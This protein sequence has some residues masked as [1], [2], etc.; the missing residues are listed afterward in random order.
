M[1]GAFLI[2]AAPRGSRGK[3]A[4][5]CRL[6][7][8]LL[9]TAEESHHETPGSPS[10]TTE[11]GP[12]GIFPHVLL[13]CLR[14]PH[15]ALLRSPCSGFLIYDTQAPARSTTEHPNKDQ[16]LAEEQESQPD[17]ASPLPA[18]IHHPTPDQPDPFLLRMAPT[19]CSSSEQCPQPSTPKGKHKGEVARN[20]KIRKLENAKFPPKLLSSF[21]LNTASP[22]MQLM[23]LLPLLR[24]SPSG[25][26]SESPAKLPPAAYNVLLHQE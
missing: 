1:Q 2:A 22:H 4:S 23:P 10:D 5:C 15:P 19:P 25:S 11:M 12:W 18:C 13:C 9:V 6:H 21:S 14:D 20:A 7:W 24:C 3:R 26:G 17:L 16:L 8:Q